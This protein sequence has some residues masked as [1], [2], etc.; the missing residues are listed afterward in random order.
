[1]KSR[2]IVNVVRK[3][4]ENLKNYLLSKILEIL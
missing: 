1:V 3:L 2:E 4:R